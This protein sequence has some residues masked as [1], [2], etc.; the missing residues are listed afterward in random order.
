MHTRLAWTIGCG[1]K[2]A[3][4]GRFSS[5]GGRCWGTRGVKKA[6]GLLRCCWD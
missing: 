5:A 6:L 2:S 1:L 3:L 4:L